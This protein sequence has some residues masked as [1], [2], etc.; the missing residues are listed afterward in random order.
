MICAQA[1][2][3][4]PT[5]QVLLGHFPGVDDKGGGEWCSLKQVFLRF[6]KKSG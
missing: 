3:Y 4:F 5:A 6:G 2:I 1:I